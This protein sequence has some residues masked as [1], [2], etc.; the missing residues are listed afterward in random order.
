MELEEFC[1]R[2]NQIELSNAQRALSILW[3]FDR[4]KP[5]L[6]MTTNELA[7]IIYDNGLGNPNTTQLRKSIEKTKLSIKE[8]SGFKLKPTAREQIKQLVASIFAEKVS[9]VEL[10][11]GYLPEEVWMNTRGYLEKIAYQVNGCFQY[12]FYDS[13]SVMMRR[14]IETLLIESYE[15]Q[16]IQNRIKDNNGEY[17][18]LSGI[19]K[20]AVD[21]NGLTLGR[22]TK[23]V[24]Q[25]IKIMGDRAAHN[26]RYNAVKADLEKVRVG[27]RLLVD[28]LIQLAELKR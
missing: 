25:E 26:R 17:L 19:V 13:A 23:R 12:G 10:K 15:S 3:F 11:N 4:D 8:R 2:L 18:M 28:E 16:S 21:R 5:G 9:N 20:D 1:I 6:T 24:L 7:K 22:E 27:V 14:M